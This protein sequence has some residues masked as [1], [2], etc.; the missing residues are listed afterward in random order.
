[1]SNEILAG[2]VAK[3]RRSSFR[4]RKSIMKECDR[5]LNRRLYSSTLKIRREIEYEFKLKLS[6]V[7]ETNCVFTILYSS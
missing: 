6:K 2:A 1:M 5:N 4:A 3:G 7:I